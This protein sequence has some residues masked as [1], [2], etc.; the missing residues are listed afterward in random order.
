MVRKSNVLSDPLTMVSAGGQADS[1]VCLRSLAEI[2]VICHAGN[3]G[4]GRGV[5]E[6]SGHRV[7]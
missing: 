4:A 7:R 6:G 1:Q 5:R 2:G 3:S